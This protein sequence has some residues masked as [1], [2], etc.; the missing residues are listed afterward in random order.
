[1]NFKPKHFPVNDQVSGRV[2]EAAKD[3][4]LGNIGGLTWAFMKACWQEERDISDPE[5]LVSIADEA[6]FDGKTL[7]AASQEARFED[8]IQQNCERAISEHGCFGSPWYVVDGESYWG[9]DRL[10]FLDAALAG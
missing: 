1:M 7:V 9:Q 10:E 5:T 4:G 8:V 6:G 2:I 3:A